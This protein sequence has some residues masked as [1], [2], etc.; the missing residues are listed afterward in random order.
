MGGSIVHSMWCMQ[1]PPIPVPTPMP[2]TV[3]NAALYL[4][5]PN[6]WQVLLLSHV[7]LSCKLHAAPSLLVRQP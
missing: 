7:L 2:K 6:V 1:D 5:G 3:M 4:Q